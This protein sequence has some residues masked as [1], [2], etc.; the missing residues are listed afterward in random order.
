MLGDEVVVESEDVVD[1]LHLAVAVGAGA[2]ADGGDGELLSDEAGER[3]GNEFQHEGVGAGV[4][5]LPG[6]LKETKG[7]VSGLALH[8]VAAELMD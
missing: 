6:I 8:A 2:D 3:S 5:Q 7:I 1:D 4:L